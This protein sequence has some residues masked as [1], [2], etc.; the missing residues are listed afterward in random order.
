MKVSIDIK[1][2]DDCPH[3]D[4]NGRLQKTTHWCCDKTNDHK[5]I[6]VMEKCGESHPI[7]IPNWCPLAKENK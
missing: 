3:L 1:S 2:C 4:H 7:K 5:K 6:K